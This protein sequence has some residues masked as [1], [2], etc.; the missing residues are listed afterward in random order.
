MAYSGKFKVK[1]IKKYKGDF[2]N[3]I[4]RSLWERHV[5]KWCDENP[6]VKQWSSEEVIIPYYYEADKRYHRYFPDIKIVFEN[7]TLLVEIKPEDQ[8]IPPTSPKRTK[9]YIAE[10]F[11]YVK[12]MNKW[13]AAES[14]C[15]DRGWEFQIWTE[16]T[17]QEMKLLPKAMPGKLKP[18]KR[19]RP[20][21]RKRKK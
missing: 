14:F 3:I 1:N 13:E 6:S 2:D 21:R 20:Y 17:L 4:Y 10:G 7:K 5:F 11:T 16:K 19:L 15:K 8:T 12:N 9:R 18:L